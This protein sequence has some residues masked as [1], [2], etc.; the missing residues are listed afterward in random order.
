MRNNSSQYVYYY[1]INISPKLSCRYVT[2]DEDSGGAGNWGVCRRGQCCGEIG[3]V[4]LGVAGA[5]PTTFQL[6]LLVGAIGVFL[7]TV[8]KLKVLPLLQATADDKSTL[9]TDLV[10]FF[11]NP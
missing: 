9:D 2:D 1:V 10:I 3:G 6:A 8:V 4:V 11:I 7:P 5:D